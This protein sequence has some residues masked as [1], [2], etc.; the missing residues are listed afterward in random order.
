M[1]LLKLLNPFIWIINCFCYFSHL[2]TQKFNKTGY[3][4]YD[5]GKDLKCF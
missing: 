1:K 3:D 4:S 2:E 5:F